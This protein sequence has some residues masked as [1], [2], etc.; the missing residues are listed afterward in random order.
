M[1]LIHFCR[2]IF[3]QNLLSHFRWDTLAGKF[4][5]SCCSRGLALAL[6]FRIGRALFHHRRV[7]F[8]FHGNFAMTPF[9]ETELYPF[10][11]TEV[12]ASDGHDLST[13]LTSQGRR[14]PKTTVIDSRIEIQNFWRVNFGIL[15]IRWVA[16]HQE[17]ACLLF[18][19]KWNKPFTSKE[20]QAWIA[21]K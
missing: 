2:R 8:L 21:V 9:P 16:R 11:K 19:D 4:W 12:Q 1:Q 14:V 20:N 5:C 17:E 10:L 13:H 15:E 3:A 18:F 6:D 7:R